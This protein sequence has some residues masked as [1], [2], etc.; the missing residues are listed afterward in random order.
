V[1]QSSS[2]SPRR[3]TR[4]FAGEEIETEERR[5]ATVGERERL[6][7]PAARILQLEVEEREG[8]KR[9][10]RSRAGGR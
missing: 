8:R 4:L 3:R 7:A 1:R 9:H 5:E 6:T 2:S 10:A